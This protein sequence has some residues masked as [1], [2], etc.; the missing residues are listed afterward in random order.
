GAAPLAAASSA[1][2][3][4]DTLATAPALGPAGSAPSAPAA[5]AG[6]AASPT[7]AA[8][9]PLPAFLP[10]PRD[11]S[12]ARRYSPWRQLVPRYWL[13]LVAGTDDG[14][15]ALGAYTSGSDVVGRHSYGAQVTAPPGD[16]GE[17]D[18]SLGWRYAG[19]GQ[20]LLDVAV[21]Q[22]WEHDPVFVSRGAQEV[23]TLTHR[24]R[25]ALVA[26]TFVRPRMRTYASL[27]VGAGY[28]MRDYATE[29][30]PLIQRLATFYRSQPR[31][32]SLF[33]SAG[34]SN[35][36]R[37]ALGISPE[38]GVSLTASAR[39]RW[40]TGAGDAGR[41]RTMIGVARG[42]K[43]LDLPGYAHHVLALRLAGGAATGTDD[44]LELGGTSGSAEELLPGLT[45]GTGQRTFGVRGFPAAALT[46][47]RAAGGTVEYRAPLTLPARGLGLFP[48]FLART[49][50]S[51]F[52]EG[53]SAWCPA[54]VAA[55][56]A[57]PDGARRAIASAGAELDVDA[58]LQYDVPYRFRFGVA[59]PIAGRSYFGKGSAAAYVTLGLA[60]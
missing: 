24:T 45:I 10:A 50:L 4:S 28:E 51:A 9:A 6:G 40:R 26:A 41:G 23:G 1:P 25:E 36:R 43:S 31:Y 22:F 18:A 14:R 19:L 30:A 47:R 44:D 55:S 33:A 34:W 13:P 3:A 49:S 53:A 46:G 27:S 32:P 58:A 56:C 20:P 29:P 39:E 42:Y 16:P 60:F 11:S 5:L 37:P 35:A 48:V 7:P 54:S 17:V 52:A 12:P 21:G 59:A 8:S 2:A 57:T 38:D 15:L